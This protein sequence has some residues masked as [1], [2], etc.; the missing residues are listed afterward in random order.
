[1]V[2]STAG[3]SCEAKVDYVV[4]GGDNCGSPTVVC[5]PASGSIF[6]KGT[7]TVNCTATDGSQNS[8]QCSFT[9][10]VNDTVPPTIACPADMV[11]STAGTSC[12]STVD[13]VLPGADN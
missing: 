4:T 6:A 9:V 12:E 8:A 7:K 2:V 3:T 1:M 13:Y 5:D 10:T 11:V